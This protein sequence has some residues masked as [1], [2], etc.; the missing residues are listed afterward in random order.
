[1]KISPFKVLAKKRNLGAFTIGLVLLLYIGFLIVSNYLSQMDL[2]ET[3]LEKLQEDTKKLTMSV[4]YFCSE[5]KMDLKN[6]S[7]NRAVSVYFEN[8]ALGMSLEYGLKASLNNIRYQFNRFLEDKK[9]GGKRIYLRLTFIGSNGEL[10]IDTGSI[11][12]EQD[13]KREWN[14]FLTPDSRDISFIDENNPQI[15]IIIVSIPY[16]F[17]GNFSGMILAWFNFV[18]IYEHFIKKDEVDSGDTSF[19]LS[20]TAFNLQR[21][22]KTSFPLL[23][24]PNF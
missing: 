8:K 23:A 4:S 16:F 11:D 6:L 20:K 3:A 14:I 12:P 24:Y 15:P 5:R 1:M 19:F 18:D 9:F 22:R 10:I 17:K 13:L 2:Q 7:E 21:M